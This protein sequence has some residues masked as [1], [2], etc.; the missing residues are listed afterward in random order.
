VALVREAAWLPRRLLTE[1]G[2]IGTS[3]GHRRR[4]ESVQMRGGGGGEQA[5]ICLS[6]CVPGS[7]LQLA[8]R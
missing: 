2:G 6:G 8:M 5:D 7:C 1:N 3:N 4:L